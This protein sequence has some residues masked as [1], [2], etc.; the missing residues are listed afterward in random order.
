MGWHIFSWQSGDITYKSNNNNIVDISYAQASIRPET[1]MAQ[2][3]I[4]TLSLSEPF[5]LL[6]G[7]LQPM[8][9]LLHKPIST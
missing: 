3:I 7:N 4:I 1:L 6:L 9:N 5:C 2:A 8:A